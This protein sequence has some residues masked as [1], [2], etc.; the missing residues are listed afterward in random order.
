MIDSA[1]SDHAQPKQVK[2]DV[3][4]NF[5]SRSLEAYIGETHKIPMLTLDE[6]R[7]LAVRYREEND[8]RAA[9]RMVMAHLRLVVSTA[10]N[11]I[12]P[13]IH[14]ADLIQ[15][16]NIGLMKAVKRF[17]ER[18]GARLG[19]YALPWIKAEMLEYLI[20][21]SR[22]A[23]VAS[24]KPQ[25]KLFFGLNKF[26]S[27]NKALTY[28]QIKDASAKLGVSE[29]DVIEMECR[30]SGSDMALEDNDA[31]EGS[32]SPINY[33]ATVE[34]EPTEVMERTEVYSLQSD[35]LAEALSSLDQRSRKIIE[36]RWLCEDGVKA[37][38]LTELAKEFGVSMERVRQIEVAAMKK[39]RGTLTAYM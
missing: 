10:R 26:K 9:H 39:M 7:S 5:Q 8:L 2:L 19:T 30:L 3:V 31:D 38:T 29:E 11:Y 4:P 27:D 18:N 28:S 13:G 36:S 25:R 22:I 21:N 24:S 12:S 37:A 17:D 33:L 15:E 6:E 14:H 32:W 35:G 34:S 20:C 16:G 1:G 23:R